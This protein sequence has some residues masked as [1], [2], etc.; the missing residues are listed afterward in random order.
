MLFCAYY[1]VFKKKYL[2]S[3]LFHYDTKRI[4]ADVKLKCKYYSIQ[5]KPGG[6]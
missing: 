1:R 6:L 2:Q 3:L 4:L 5:I